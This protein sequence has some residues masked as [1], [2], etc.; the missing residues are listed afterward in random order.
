VTLPSLL[1]YETTQPP[2]AALPSFSSTSPT[3]LTLRTTSSSCIRLLPWAFAPQP[4]ATGFRPLYLIGSGFYFNGRG[5]AWLGSAWLQYPSA[6]FDLH[7][8]NGAAW[9]LGSPPDAIPVVTVF[10][11]FY[12]LYASSFIYFGRHCWQGVKALHGTEHTSGPGL[13]MKSSLYSIALVQPR[14]L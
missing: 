6:S 7:Y 11:M 13:E 10:C 8:E 12:I 1:S 3:T 5:V 2:S 9:A 4:L 14:A